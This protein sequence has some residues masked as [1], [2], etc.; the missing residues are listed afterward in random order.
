MWYLDFLLIMLTVLSAGYGYIGW[1]LASPM[2]RGRKRRAAWLVVLGTAV[3]FFGCCALD[4][5][6][7][8]MIRR[9]DV[10]LRLKG[11]T[12]P[13][14]IVSLLRSIL[15]AAVDAGRLADVPKFPKYRQPKK[16]AR[17]PRADDVLL[18]LEHCA[19]WLRTAVGLMAFAGLRTSEATA[20]VVGDVS[21]EQGVVTVRRTHSGDGATRAV[22][23]TKGNAD[24]IVPLTEGL[25]RI[26]AEA[27]RG[28]LPGAPVL[29][30]EDGHV[31]R[32]QH[33]YDRLVRAQER[34]GLRRHGG[35]AL[36]HFFCSEV[37]AG[38]ASAETVRVLAGH[39]DLRTTQRYLHTASAEHFAAVAHLDRLTK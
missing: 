2:E 21:F 17:C 20:L 22:T 13:R 31:P 32:R 3:P 28:K 5:I 24:R 10:E 8:A 34:A 30:T 11:I 39:R 15:S 35:H 16:I 7:A 14:H 36:R 9:F 23:N 18:L 25:R 4:A 19:G 27:C 33:V 6:D 29:L 37:L 38:G 12:S 1:L 26:L